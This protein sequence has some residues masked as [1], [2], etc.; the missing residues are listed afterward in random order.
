[1]VGEGDPVI[2][3]FPDANAALDAEILAADARADRERILRARLKDVR[4][5]IKALEIETDVILREL[6]ELAWEQP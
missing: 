4:D 1:M 5:T 3:K 6:S 2:L